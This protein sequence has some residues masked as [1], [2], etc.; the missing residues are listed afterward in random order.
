[1]EFVNIYLLPFFSWVLQ[2]SMMASVMVGLILLIK[3]VLGNR[4]SP[5]WHYLLWILV[6][7]RLLLLWAPESSLSIYNMLP[8][9]HETSPTFHIISSLPSEESVVPSSSMHDEGKKVESAS[10]SPY[11]LGLFIWIVGVFC[12]GMVAIVVNRRVYLHIKKQSIITDP[13]VIQ[14]FERCKKKMSVKRSIPL[15]VS[16]GISSPTVFGFMRPRILLSD[17]L[18]QTLG[19]KQ[20]QFIFYHELA[21]IKR[22]D[23]GINL[24]MHALLLLHW[25]NPLLWYAYYRMREDQ[26]IACDARALTYIDSEQKIEYGH[27]IIRL[28]EHYSRNQ[29]LP[30]L[31]NL[32]G[33]KNQLKKRILMIKNFHKAS[34][35]LSTLGLV[36]AIVISGASLVNA[37]APSQNTVAQ[38]PDSAGL[39]AGG[40]KKI[41]ASEALADKDVKAALDRVH[42]LFPE[43]ES[44]EINAFE[45]VVSPDDE[46]E[47]DKYFI[48]LKRDSEDFFTFDFGVDSKTGKISYTIRSLTASEVLSYDNA[49]SG[50]DKIHALH[51]E[52]KSYEIT[53][54]NV[55]DNFVGNFSRYN[56]VF[57]DKDSKDLINFGID[58]KTGEIMPDKKEDN[59]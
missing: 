53:G 49:K 20:L 29:Y 25:F 6:I 56:I 45:Y 44:Y 5:R 11:T 58:A 30:S 18:L 16:N 39:Y 35:R 1:M 38:K 40:Y 46:G 2:T 26:E 3:A 13:R 34:Y 28:L 19:D 12:F 31:A 4:L 41:T 59:L 27:T 17:T 54:A 21:H 23:V 51:P 48:K 36:A 47:Y 52:T 55:I 8:Y 15:V 57:R 37:K 50:V 33:S 43:T 7:L 24:L 14:L 22:N 32:V 9:S 42:A 10:L